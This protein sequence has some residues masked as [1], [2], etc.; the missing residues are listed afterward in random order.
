[1]SEPRHYDFSRLGPPKGARV[2]VSGGC[3]GI[4]RAIVR[5]CVETDLDVAVLD[6]QRTHDQSPVPKGVR[7]IPFD[8]HD[9]DSVQAAFAALAQHRPAIDAVMNLVGAG[10][11]PGPLTTKDVKHF[12]EDISRN[13]R[14]AF[15]ISKHA[16]PLLK[17]SGVGSLVHTASGVAY[18]PLKNVGAYAAAKGGLVSLSKT[19]AIENAPDVRV[20]VV[21]PGGVSNKVKVSAAGAIG[22]GGLDVSAVTRMIPLGR[23]AEP[24]DLVGAFLFLAG[25]MSRQ[26]TGQVLH[27]NGG[28]V[29]P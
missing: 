26:M 29:M 3:G 14:S 12:D 6:L 23:V 2:V 9:E 18:R 24:E 11:A 17:A 27:V 4:G 20:N 1:M 22:P 25:P 28:A 13:L 10:N 21:A 8:A 7:F 15:L 5:A 19:L 16:M